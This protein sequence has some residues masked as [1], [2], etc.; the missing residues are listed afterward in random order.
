MKMQLGN[1]TTGLVGGKTPTTG[2]SLI[3]VSSS[4]SEER[5][6]Y[7]GDD[8]DFSNEPAPRLDNSKF[9]HIIEEETQ[10]AASGTELPLEILLP[11]RILFLLQSSLFSSIIQILF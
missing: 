7:S 10:M 1:P 8:H 4:S 2:A 6:D 9:S 11:L 5:V 3:Q